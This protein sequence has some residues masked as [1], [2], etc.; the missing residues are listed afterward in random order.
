MPTFLKSE[1]IKGT[2]NAVLIARYCKLFG[3]SPAEEL[4][5]IDNHM[6]VAVNWACYLAYQQNEND[7][8][9]EAQKTKE[10]ETLALGQHLD[11]IKELEEASKSRGS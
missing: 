4:G 5:I 1:P 11:L 6:R 9:S 3:I 7:L 2:T 8:N 10:K